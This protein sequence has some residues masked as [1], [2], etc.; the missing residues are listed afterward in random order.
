MSTRILI[1]SCTLKATSM[2]S[3][4]L[5]HEDALL[6][7]GVMT[8]WSVSG[9]SLPGLAGGYWLDIPRKVGTITS[10]SRIVILSTS[11]SLQRG[12]RFDSPPSVFRV[13]GR[14]RTGLEPENGGMPIHFNW[15]HI[16]CW[17][18]RLVTVTPGLCCGRFY[19]SHLGS[20]YGRGAPY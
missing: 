16:S 1:T 20:R 11:H 6:F 12:P 2:P 18:P 4:H 9:T 5:Q 13:H 14:H 7:P 19:A 17:P 3:V 15:S 10:A 8:L